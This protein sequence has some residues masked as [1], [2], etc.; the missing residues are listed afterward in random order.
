VQEKNA[1][2]GAWQTHQKVGKDCWKRGKITLIFCYFSDKSKSDAW[3]F[4]Y[5]DSKHITNISDWF[6]EFG[7]DK[8]R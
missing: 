5:G 7:E 8:S 4:D 1:G 6:V 3:Y 2:F